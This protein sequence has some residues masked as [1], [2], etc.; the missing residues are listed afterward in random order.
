MSSA[1]GECGE[2]GPRTVARAGAASTK[3]TGAHSMQGSGEASHGQGASILIA[4][5]LAPAPAATACRVR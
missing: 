2:G 3:L 5:G 1:F 4:A